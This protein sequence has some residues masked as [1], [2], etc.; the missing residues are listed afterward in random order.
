MI[1]RVFQKNDLKLEVQRVSGLADQMPLYP[2]NPGD[3]R[4]RRIT[5]VVPVLR[6]PS[7]PETL[8]EQVPETVSNGITP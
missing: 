3:P 1:R 8:G 5:V 6:K 7:K 4:N 2:G